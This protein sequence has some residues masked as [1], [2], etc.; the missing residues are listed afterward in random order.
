[1]TDERPTELPADVELIRTTDLFSHDTVPAGLLGI[2]RVARGTW[3]RIVVASGELVFHF[4]ESAEE[5]HPPPP[6]TLRAGQTLVIPPEHPH[7]VELVGPTNFK[8]EFHS[9]VN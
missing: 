3:G 9:S 5:A 7:R 2:H 1:M 4:V 6:I 8:V